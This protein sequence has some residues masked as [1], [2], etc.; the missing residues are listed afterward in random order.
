MSLSFCNYLVSW[1]LVWISFK[2]K[3]I[4][5]SV[6]ICHLAFKYS[7][8]NFTA[9]WEISFKTKVLKFFS[10]VVILSKKKNDWFFFKLE[11]L[12]QNV[13]NSSKL[14]RMFQSKA[15]K[16]LFDIYICMFWYF[17]ALVIISCSNSQSCISQFVWTIQVD[18]SNHS[19]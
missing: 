1:I 12:S 15:Y 2:P 18:T 19:N 3:A 16:C 4:I 9:N 11:H 10:N 7:K 6:F 14:L 13:V 8:A 5:V 17:L